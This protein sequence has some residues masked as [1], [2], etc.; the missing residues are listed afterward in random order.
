MLEIYLMYIVIFMPENSHNIQVAQ[1]PTNKKN[2]VHCCVIMTSSKMKAM[3]NR[4]SK[5]YNPYDDNNT[6]IVV[7]RKISVN[8][9]VVTQFFVGFFTSNISSLFNLI[10]AR[11]ALLI[12]QF[13]TNFHLSIHSLSFIVA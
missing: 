4:N 1:T 6:R 10:G 2:S 11:T 12:F 13:A 7:E 9:T 8:E 5:E 3:C